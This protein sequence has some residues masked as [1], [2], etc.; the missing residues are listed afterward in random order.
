MRKCKAMLKAIE[1]TRYGL[2]HKGKTRRDSFSL[3]ELHAFNISM[4]SKERPR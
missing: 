3:K 2:A 1:A 4:T